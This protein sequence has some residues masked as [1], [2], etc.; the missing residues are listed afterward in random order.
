MQICGDFGGFA[1]VSQK[2]HNYYYFCYQIL[3]VER[4]LGGRGGAGGWWVGGCALLYKRSYNKVVD[5]I[6]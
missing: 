4:S 3:A 6:R 5:S 2:P 1:R